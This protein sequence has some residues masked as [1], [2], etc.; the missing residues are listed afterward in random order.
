MLRTCVI[1][2]ALAGA[3]GLIV[4]CSSSKDTKP[5]S[6]DES[7]KSYKTQLG[8]FDKQVD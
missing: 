2:C 6:K 3:A 1:C 7:L 8:A 5:T 4:G